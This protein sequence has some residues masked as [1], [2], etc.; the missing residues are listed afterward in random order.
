M[1]TANDLEIRANAIPRLQRAAYLTEIAEPVLHRH[2]VSLFTRAEE[3]TRAEITH[4]PSELGRDI[5]LRREDPF[6]KQ[7]VGVVVKRHPYGKGNLTGKTAGPIDEIISQAHQTIMHKCHLKDIAAETV[8]I[9][10]VWIVFFGRMSKTAMERLRRETADIRGSRIFTLEELVDLFTTHYPEVFFDGE[11]SE[12]LTKKI[13]ELETL[14]GIAKSPNKLSDRFINPRVTVADAR[15]DLTEEGLSYLF[16]TENIPFGRLDEYIRPRAKI[17]LTGDPGSGKS[18]ALQKIALD[19]FR[20]AQETT[21]MATSG[22]RRSARRPTPIPVLINAVSTREGKT[23]EQLIEAEL[24]PNEVR[25]RFSIGVML[26]DGLD[27]VPSNTV[28]A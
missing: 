17:V 23:L 2:L 21:L 8:S 27:E 14:E 28:S 7:Y 18:T 13:I 4:G 19:M 16:G 12:Y 11:V 20:D 15:V 25:D 24:P 10:T 3:N 26:F 1:T 9:S 22:R 5:V 6:G